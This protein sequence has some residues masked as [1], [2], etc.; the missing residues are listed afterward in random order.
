MNYFFVFQNKTFKEERAGKFLWAP[1]RNKNGQTFHHWTSMTKVN[2]GDVIFNSYNGE[3]LAIIVAKESCKDSIRPS[4]LDSVELWEEEG[5]RVEAEYFDVKSPIKYKDYMDDIKRMQGYKYAPFNALGRG[6]TGYLFQIQEELAL[7]LFSIM[8]F[9]ISE[10]SL[11]EQ[12]ENVEKLI[13][14]SEDDVTN[15]FETTYKE[16]LVKTRIGQGIF[17]QRL[18][19]LE[20]KCKLCGVDNINFLRASHSKPWRESSHNERLNRFNGFLLCPAHDVLYDRGYIS[21][22]ENG[23][24][25]ISDELD[26][27][28]KVLLNIHANMKIN[29]LEGHR[30]FLQYHREN[31]FRK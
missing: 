5:W 7:F 2:Q 17:K 3:S 27:R 20:C 13:K 25:I 19:E 23:Q 26:D 10:I 18:S 9:N 1:K 21:F 14:E 31:I 4:D 8:N 16:Q 30:E 28:S 15:E 12:Y 24:I 29:L 22:Q 6:N 11:N